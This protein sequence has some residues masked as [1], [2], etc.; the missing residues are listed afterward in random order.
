[1]ASRSWREDTFGASEEAP[2]VVRLGDE[3]I[4]T[5]V[6]PGDD[7]PAAARP[8]SIATGGMMPRGADAVVMV[9]HADV[10]PGSC[11]SRGP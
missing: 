2:R 9:E 8:L 10:R 3:M 1:M 5:G 11:G 4:H 6:V 7:R